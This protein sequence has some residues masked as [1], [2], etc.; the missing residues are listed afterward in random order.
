MIIRP[1]TPADAAA[2]ATLRYDFRSSRS[3]PAESREEF[4]PRCRAWMASELASGSWRAW[5]A[6]TDAGIVGQIWLNVIR[7]L[8][9]PGTERESHGYISNLFVRPETRGGVGT[10]LLEAVLAYASDERLD[11]IVLWATPKSRTLYLRYGFKPG[12]DVFERVCP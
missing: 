10:R 11:R 4:E 5:L 1:A 9:N 7:K 3:T 6:E 2:L 12:G 8:P